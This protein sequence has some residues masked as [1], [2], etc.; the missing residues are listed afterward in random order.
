MTSKLSPQQIQSEALPFLRAIFPLRSLDN[1]PTS[2]QFIRFITVVPVVEAFPGHQY[3]FTVEELH[4][5]DITL[6]FSVD[7]NVYFTPH[8]YVSKDSGKRANASPLCST[9]WIECDDEYFKPQTIEE[10]APSI[11]VETS[12]RRTHAYWILREPEPSELVEMINK[13]LTYKY[14]TRDRSGWDLSQLLRVPGFVNHK[15]RTP[16]VVKMI[17]FEPT[18]LFDIASFDGLP[19]APLNSVSIDNEGNPLPNREHARDENTPP[20]PEDITSPANL[21]VTYSHLITPSMREILAKRAPDRSRALWR[22]YNECRRAGMTPE[23]CFSLSSTSP[24]NKFADAKYNGET[25]LWRDVLA[26]YRIEDSHD[27]HILQALED[28]RLTK[29][30]KPS[31]RNEQISREIYRH[32]GTMG[33]FFHS[34]ATQETFYHKDN[35]LIA[36][37]EHSL[38]LRAHLDLHYE[39]NPANP[40]F[41]YIAWH[42]RD[43]ASEHGAHITLRNLA[44]FD[45]ERHLLYVTDHAG[46]TF[47]LDGQKIEWIE[48]GVDG[49]VFFRDPPFADPIKIPSPVLPQENQQASFKRMLDKTIL[50]RPNLGVEGLQP[51][52]AKFLL[53]SWIY[54]MFFSE[55]ML[56]RPILVLEGVRGSGKTTFFKCLS[57]LLIGSERDVTDLPSDQASFKEAVR[58]QHHVFLDGVD[59]MWPGLQ[60][61]LSTVATGTQERRRVLYTDNDYATYRLQCFL[62]ISTQDARFLR[63]DVADRSIIMST[64]RI[65]GT[66]TLDSIKTEVMEHRGEIWLEILQDLNALV[67]KLKTF[68]MH[69]SRIRMADFAQILFALCEIRDRDAHLL[70][71]YMRG[72]QDRSV[73]SRDPIWEAL[74]SW[75]RTPGNEGKWVTAAQLHLA[76]AQIAGY[77]G[78]M[79]TRQVRSA[80]VLA[81]KLRLLM[82][83]LE[84]VLK[85]EIDTRGPKQVYSFI[86]KVPQEVEVSE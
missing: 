64:I 50:S 61:L 22:F 79:Y 57:W 4:N 49:D 65:D 58:D 63:D 67:E 74:V 29:G 18:K 27:V 25:E 35:V 31:D 66:E 41:R 8:T 42:L 11:V 85:V 59:T 81:H 9:I 46:G 62:G 53:R 86:H 19:T 34:A 17:D 37:T 28:I 71:E 60:N 16:H 68:K 47:R 72:E 56:S 23:E 40:E 12:P 2:K 73:L 30:G 84:G 10:A 78:M 55:I 70:T 5:P 82:P 75:L 15:R 48:N 52:D 54:S 24:N 76:L 80:N 51:K 26:G 77:G 14:L 33:R 83:N 69:Q 7:A 13:A 43:H 38:K 6:P 39:I 36:L 45:K 20:L 32:M 1:Q 3:W 21:L 44:Y